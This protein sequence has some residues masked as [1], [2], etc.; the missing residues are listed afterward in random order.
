MNATRCPPSRVRVP[1]VEDLLTIGVSRVECTA[2]QEFSVPPSSQNVELHAP[3]PSVGTIP[4]NVVVAV[5]LSI[6]VGR[7]TMW[8][9]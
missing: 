2:G 7:S 5:A 8:R 3:A 9:R 1:R 4:E 6:T